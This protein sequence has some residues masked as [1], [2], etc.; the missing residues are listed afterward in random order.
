MLLGHQEHAEVWTK[1][2]AHV[3]KEKVHK[4]QRT[5]IPPGSLHSLPPLRATIHR[6]GASTR[7]WPWSTCWT[8]KWLEWLPCY[9]DLG[10]FEPTAIGVCRAIPDDLK[11]LPHTQ[12]GRETL[13]RVFWEFDRCPVSKHYILN[14]PVFAIPQVGHRPAY[15]H[16]LQA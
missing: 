9:A 8:E 5:N 7:L 14:F 11:L 2:T 3:G 15:T 16:L 6:S 4:V 1:R 13:N 10:C 12:P